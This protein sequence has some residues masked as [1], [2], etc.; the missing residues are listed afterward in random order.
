MSEQDLSAAGLFASDEALKSLPFSKYSQAASEEVLLR[1]KAGLESKHHFC[2]IVQSKTEALELVKSLIPADSSVA[3]G[4]STTLKEIGLIDF[5]KTETGWNNLHAK[6]LA[7]PDQGKAAELRR[8]SMTADYYLSSVTA[9]SEQGDLTVCDA[10]G[11]RC[12][13]FTFAA[14]KLIIV[15]GSNKIVPNYEEALQRTQ[16]YCFPLES[17]RARIAYGVPGS[18]LNN[19]VAIRGSSP[20]SPP[21]R[22][23]VIIV[24]ESL[25]Y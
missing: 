2:T 15:A 10:T 19:F 23:H 21:G 8:L 18:M 7:E 25:G 14:K 13:P 16:E 17:A 1:A 12:G 22:F 5:L 6:I 24:K 20:W 3:T 9:I 11:N 4:G